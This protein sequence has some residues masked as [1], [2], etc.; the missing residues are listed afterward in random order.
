MKKRFRLLQITLLAFSVFLL[1][2]S[3][4][5]AWFSKVN[6]TNVITIDSASLKVEAS[7]Y[8]AGHSPSIPSD[9]DFIL[10]ENSIAFGNVI[11]GERYHFK[12]VVKNIGSI[13]GKLT[14]NVD[15]ID[16]SP[17]LDEGIFLFNV[18]ENSNSILLNQNNIL[19]EDL[20]IDDGNEVIL[21]FSIELSGI[22]HSELTAEYLRLN[23]INIR[24]D[25]IQE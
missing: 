25:Q 9:D 22:A 6:Q 16:H 15:D 11:P 19:F 13:P 12:L 1:L 20:I 4:T 5:Y 21:N 23:H 3:V 18:K 7:L 17:N 10:V 24:L 14:V 2:G 8:Q